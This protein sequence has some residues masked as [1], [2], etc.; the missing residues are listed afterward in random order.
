MIQNI[1]F[2][3]FITM[4]AFVITSTIL[5][6]FADKLIVEELRKLR[7]R[8]PINNLLNNLPGRDDTWKVWQNCIAL[9][10]ITFVTMMVM[11]CTEW[12]TVLFW[13]PIFW[14][15]WSIVHEFFTGLF[16]MEDPW[17]V[18]GDKTS[19]WIARI[20]QQSGILIFSVKM[21]LLFLLVTAYL[22][23]SFNIGFW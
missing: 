16:I 15:V 10:W 5:A 8:V 4:A 7:F 22:E 6:A 13:I 1:E 9:G 11:A 2:R 20:L 19:Q 18:S 12:W 14:M 21:F 23:I 3:A 17:H